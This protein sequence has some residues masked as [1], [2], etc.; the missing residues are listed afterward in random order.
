MASVKEKIERAIIE[1]ETEEISEGRNVTLDTLLNKL[2]TKLEGIEITKEENTL[3]GTY[4]GYDFVI[5]ENFEVTI[6][7]YNPSEDE[8]SDDGSQ[9]PPVAATYNVTFNGPNVTSNGASTINENETYTATLTPTTG[10]GV[11]SIAI[12]MGGTTLVENTGYTYTN[13]VITIANV[14]GNI[15]ITIVAEEYNYDVPY[16]PTGFKYKE[17]AWNNGYTIIGETTSIGDEFVWVPCV[18][19]Q[20]KVKDGDTVV[21]YGKTLPSTTKTTDPYY[22]YNK[23]N[24]G[25][26]PTDTSVAVEDSSV[27]EIETSVGTYGGFYIAKYEAGIEGT[28][29]NNSLPTKTAT[30]GSVKPLSQKDKGVWNCISRTN[31]ITVSKAMIDQTTTGAKSTLISGEAWD[32]TLQWMVNASDNKDS[33]PNLGYDTNSSGKGWYSD[34]SSK[35]RCLTGY[36]AVN[37][38][39]DIAGNVWD[40]TTENGTSRGTSIVVCRGGYCYNTGDFFPA[41]SRSYL[42]VVEN[43]YVGFR[44]LLYK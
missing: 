3:K 29:E 22:M 4:D 42:T 36:Y 17:G 24:L 10:Y 13:G 34:V 38:I 40:W 7:G 12:T 15:E 41:A 21:T 33:E 28:T 35:D 44:V 32:T 14:I 19:D 5:D 43:G 26:L 8:E 16:I 11:T 25:L 30:D 27:A 2:P 31:A 1:I 23:D 39:Y 18:L 37:N 20:T 9:Q 6:E